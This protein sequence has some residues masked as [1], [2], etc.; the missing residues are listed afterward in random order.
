[1][2]AL[3]VVD[4]HGEILDLRAASTERL[5]QCIDEMNELRARLRDVE[6]IVARELLNRMDRQ[7]LWTVRVGDY[8]IKAASP[9]VGCEVYPE[10]E[11]EEA[12]V[13]LVDA[14][15]I[16]P[17]AASMALKRTVEAS[18]LVPW[19]ADV[20]E[21]ASRLVEAASVE[22]AGRRVAVLRAE[23]EWRVAKQGIV[24][25][26]KVPGARERID[27]ARRIVDPPQRR[28]KVSVR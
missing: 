27:G 26:R 23:P 13:E 25:L 18:F 16:S 19:D 12:L 28:V 2:S 4:H 11:L 15:V 22:I 21:V 24:K 17:E 14:Q 1:M 6:E 10:R 5:A 20:R 8:E 9:N 3:E 7:A